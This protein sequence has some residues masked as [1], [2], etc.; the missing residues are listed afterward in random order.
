M[1]LTCQCQNPV[2]SVS[3]PKTDV[4]HKNLKLDGYSFQSTLQKYDGSSMLL[5][6]KTKSQKYVFIHNQML[7]HLI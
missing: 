7:I 2:V 5:F 1:A 4:L 3:F 6:F